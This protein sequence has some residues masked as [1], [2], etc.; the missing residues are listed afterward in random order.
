MNELLRLALRSLLRNRRRSGVTL[1]A[2]ALGVAIVIFG[3]GFGEGF[4]RMMIKNQIENRHGAIQIHR[5]GYLDASEAAPLDL[6]LPD[7]EALMAK[8]RAVPGVVA[9]SP[10]IRFAAMIG[11]GKTSS[12]VMG[13][14]IDPE[15]ELEVC[16]GRKLD[17][18]PATGSYVTKDIVNGGVLGHE[19]ARAFHATP[20]DTLTL[21]GSGRE[22]GVNA[23]DLQVAGVSRGAASVFE[24]KRSVVVPLEYTQNLL[25]MQG[26]VTEIAVRVADLESIPEVAA[27]L[28]VALG[29]EVEVSTWDEVLPYLKDML[30]RLA[31]ILRGVSAVLFFIVIFGVINTM[32]MNVYERVRE[33]GTMLAVGVTRRQVLALF[34][35]EAGV[36]GLTGG[37]LGAAL[38]LGLSVVTAIQGWS[39]TSPGGVYPQ[40]VHPV[41]RL[42]LAALTLVAAVVG[43]IV[44]AAWPARK[45]SLMNPV[46]ALRT[47]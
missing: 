1:G 20:G 4:T 38:G 18:D 27:A 43:A 40:V 3:H 9:V 11:D 14:G 47:L 2:V 8:A 34:F 35:F 24:S 42:D 13:E 16:P 17:V 45:A 44:A 19:L 33:I 29:P 26:R 21:S 23:L 46:D 37:L 15:R 41:A 10:R 22:G 36:I 39:L 5:K 32:L 12:I 31:V 25:Q 7:A 30:D 28:R 6:D